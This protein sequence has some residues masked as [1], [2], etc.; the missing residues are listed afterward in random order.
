MGGD[1]T[2]S[3]NKDTERPTDPRPQSGQ[4]DPGERLLTVTPK[5]LRSKNPM[6]L[7]YHI[8]KIY[9]HRKFD[10]KSK[11]VGKNIRPIL[12]APA[13]SNNKLISLFSL[14]Y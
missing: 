14:K 13:W 9:A 11:V 7:R 10:K 5:Y 8:F 3:T 4:A 2:D 1:R 6:V 12:H